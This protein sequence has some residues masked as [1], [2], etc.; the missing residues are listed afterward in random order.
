MNQE[1]AEAIVKWEDHEDLDHFL[2]ITNEKL[3]RLTR[4][5]A[6][7]YQVVQDDRDQK[8][9]RINWMRGATE[10]QDEGP[11]DVNFHQVEPN[12]IKVIEY[13]KVM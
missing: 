9:W 1:I 4:W 3:Y 8:Y 6:H 12:E 7:Y 11:E 2:A 13:V 10:M 5:H